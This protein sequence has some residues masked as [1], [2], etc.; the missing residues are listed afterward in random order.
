MCGP[1]VGKTIGFTRCTRRNKKSDPNNYRGIHLTAQ[2]SKVVERILGKLFLPYMESIETCGPL[3]FAYRKNRGLRAAL[4][5]NLMSWIMMF[6]LGKRVAL[7]C[8]D[9]S[10]VFDRVSTER[11]CKKLKL[12][13]MRS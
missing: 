12:C 6:H 13:G 7:Y 1:I 5:F 11:L 9:V 4:D 10:G 8:S 3:Q 2:L